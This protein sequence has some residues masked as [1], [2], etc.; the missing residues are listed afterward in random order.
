MYKGILTF[1]VLF[2]IANA[3]CPAS[4]EISNLLSG[5]P[6]LI[7]ESVIFTVDDTPRQ[8]YTSTFPKQFATT[9]S[10]ALGTSYPT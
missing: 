9:P 2:A 6:C 7:S 4:Y 5:T 1:L 8:T 10:V 3:Q